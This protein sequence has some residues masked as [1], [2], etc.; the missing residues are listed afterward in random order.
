MILRKVSMWL[1][2]VA[3]MAGIFI[4]SSL[5][6]GPDLPGLLGWDKL[7]HY[8]IYAGLGTLLVRTIR[9]SQARWSLTTVALTAVS[10]ASAYGLTDEFHQLYVPVRHCDIMDWAADILG[11]I[12]GAL[13]A[14]VFS[15]SKSKQEE[16]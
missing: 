10:V 16:A 5:E 7:K 8:L 12:T 13:L 3:Y 9:R 15:H 1:P 6:S 2:V 4:L 14:L 11:S